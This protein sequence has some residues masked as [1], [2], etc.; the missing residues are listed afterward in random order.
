M[1]K[2]TTISILIAI[3]VVLQY[4]DNILSLGLI[5]GG[6]IGLANIVNIIA[7]NMF[8]LN[9]N[10]ANAKF[11]DSYSLFVIRY[12]F[13]IVYS[14]ALSRALL[15]GLIGAGVLSAAYSICGSLLAVSVMLAVRPNRNLSY[16][17]IGILGASSNNLGQIL[18]ACLLLKSYS[19]FAY[20]PYLL[21]L[22]AFTGAAVG[23]IGQ[24]LS[25]RLFRTQ[26]PQMLRTA[27]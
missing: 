4:V 18:F 27:D 23:Y 11:N 8:C 5:T 2:L 24:L 9:K 6:K 1:K 16:I 26:M 21:L 3:G 10:F 20:F 12:S 25:V 7:I 13:G 15:G 17:G 19:P 14:I 22:S